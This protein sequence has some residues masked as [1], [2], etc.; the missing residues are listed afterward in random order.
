MT[1]PIVIAA[2]VLFFVFLMWRM[3]PDISGAEAGELVKKGAR[4]LDVRTAGEFAGGGLPKARNVPVA[5]LGGR[6]GELGDKGKPIVVYCATGSRS[7]MAKRMLV[8]AGFQT[9]RNLGAM[10][11]W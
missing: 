6:F 5:D 1:I 3:R 4:L 9:V 11:R 7:A 2:A 10:S 8:G